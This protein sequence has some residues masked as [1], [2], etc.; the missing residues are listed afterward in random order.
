MSRRPNSESRLG[1]AILRL[2]RTTIRVEIDRAEQV[3]SQACRGPDH[4]RGHDETALLAVRE[5]MPVQKNSTR[6]PQALDRFG[7]VLEGARRF[8]IEPKPVWSEGSELGAPSSAQ[9]D[10]SRDRCIVGEIGSPRS[11]VRDG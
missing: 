2:Y 6:R 5:A 1:L 8:R 10:S 11:A 3:A 9:I 7:L 4:V